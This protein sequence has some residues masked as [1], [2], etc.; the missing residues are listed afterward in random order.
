LNDDYIISIGGKYSDTINIYEIHT[1]KWHYIGRLSSQ[2][3]GAYA[4]LNE[5][6]NIVYIA[7]GVNENE[8]NTLDIEYFRLTKNFD[9]EIMTKSIKDDYLLRK[10]NP[11]VIP[12]F[13]YNTYIIC[14]GAGIWGNVNTCVIYYTDKDAVILS[15]NTLPKPI[16][17]ENHN[18]HFYK[19]AVYFFSSCDEV[20]KYNGLDN[21]YSVVKRKSD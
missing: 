9:S 11:V 7:G 21:S 3:Y 13:D 4:L 20:I 14:G 5:Y 16:A 15:N 2:R 17:T 19:E 12:I 6:E 8:D 1:D 10:I 18:V